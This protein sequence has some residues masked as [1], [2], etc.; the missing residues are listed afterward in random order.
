MPAQRR[1]LALTDAYRERVLASRGRLQALA[2]QRWPTIDQLD[3]TVWPDRMAASVA[4]AQLAAVRATG[5]YLSLYL[6]SET[7]K[8]QRGPQ[9][10][11]RAYAGLSRDGRPLTESLRSPLIGVRFGLK[12]VYRATGR[13]MEV[14]PKQ[15]RSW[16]QGGTHAGFDKQ[17]ALRLA[18]KMRSGE[19]D[20]TRAPI[21]IARTGFVLDGQHRLQAIVGLGRPITL[22]VATN[23]PDPLRE[24]ASRAARMVGVDFDHAHRTAL[25]AAIDADERIDGWQRALRGTCGACAGI[26]TGPSGGLRFEVHPGCF[27]AGTEV[28]G[29]KASAATTRRYV[30]DLI[31]I[32]LRNGFLSCTPNHPILT[33]SGWV[34]AG[35]LHEG[36]DVIRSLGTKRGVGRVHPDHDERPTL[37]EQVAE[38]LASSGP[39]ATTS[40]PVAPE[41][42]H[43]DGFGGDVD[44]VWADSFGEDRRDAT[45]LQQFGEVPLCLGCMGLLALAGVGAFHALSQRRLPPGS[46]TIGGL[47]IATTL[48]GGHRLAPHDLRLGHAADGHT[49][50]DQAPSNNDSLKGQAL[51]NRKF[52]LAPE[53]SGNDLLVRRNKALRATG[54]SPGNHLAS[55]GGE[56]D[57]SL[58]TSLSEGRAGAVEVDRVVHLRRVGFRGHVYNLQ[59]EDHWYIANG[60][61]VHNCQ[62]VSEPIVAGVPSLFPQPTGQE[63]FD[64][65]TTAEQDEML[66]PDAAEKVRDGLP[67]TELVE[68]SQ[69]ETAD[70]FITQRP[71][72]ALT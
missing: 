12:E 2:V 11:A 65:K 40:M 14:T 30:G 53:V 21:R 61:V 51:A 35:E 6:S 48:L 49:S 43:G 20:S 68:T 45:R 56:S 58:A 67:L 72:S 55:Q 38:S 52:G 22:S 4:Q 19:W 59:S 60:I 41:D 64:A 24:G 50:F 7:G 33:P 15:A 8:R 71:V 3:G 23:L 9:I 29:P 27:P 32:R 36:S 10:D 62:C 54:D 70:D 28:S 57:A 25:L 18:Q 69:I 1:S 26:A 46:G 44:V 16:L 66:G 42:F 37:I 34:P 13:E 63:T 17:R 5:A 47:G 39:V 31:E